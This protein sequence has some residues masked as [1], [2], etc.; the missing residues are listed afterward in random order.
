MSTLEDTDIEIGRKVLRQEAAALEMLAGALG[1]S[2]ADAVSR[3]VATDG[4]VICSGVG[5]SGHVARKMAATLSSTGTPSYF[6]H[7]T[8]ASHGDLGMI[9]ENDVIVA[10]SRSGDTT[11]LDDLVQY[12][13]RF[14]VTL[15]A[16]TAAAGGALA[17]K[18]DIVLLVPN[19]PEACAET[20]AP[21]T[22]TTM[23]MALGDALAVALL[24]RRGFDE[25]RFKLFHP[26]GKLGAMLKTAGDLM[27][28]GGAIPLVEA[29][30]AF[31]EALATLSEKHLGCV[32]VIDGEGALVGIITDGDVRRLFS[33]RVAPRTAADAMTKR[34]I[35]MPAGTL[36]ATL[37]QIMNEKK[38]TQIFIVDGARPVGVV[39]LHDVLKAGVV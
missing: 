14:G 9:Q 5:K 30:A 22:S 11:E 35:A 16:I 3:I 2:F 33:K 36:A 4:R 6:V 12:S 37:V 18:A 19:A 39:H 1:G 21:T 15:I 17:A 13:R 31:E 7:P 20:R 10:I 26:G 8:E 38:I 32:G 28:T 27:L 25:A 23:M 24:R 34:P 29:S